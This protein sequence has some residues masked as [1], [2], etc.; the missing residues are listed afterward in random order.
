MHWLRFWRRRHWDEERARELTSYIEHETNENRARGMSLW[1][2]QQAAHRKLGNQTLIREEIYTMNSLGWIETLWQDVRYGLRVLAKS[3]GATLVAMISLAL[4]IGATTAIFSAFYGVLISPYPYARPGEIW[5]PAIVTA[6]N[7]NLPFSFH[8][9]RDYL[10]LKKLPAFA[11]AMAT[12]PENRLL[13][14]GRPPE[15][16]Q[17]ISVTANAFQFLAVPPILGRTILPSDAAQGGQPAPVIVLSFKAWNRLFNS[18]PDALGKKLILNDEPFTV[19]GV[20]PPRFGWWTDQGGWLVLPETPMDTR[21]AAPIFRL[22]PGVPAAAA[23]QQLHALYVRL[24]QA[25]PNDFP[26]NGFSTRLRN[27]LDIT[28]ASGEMQSSLQLLFGAVGFLLLIACA[29]V[30]NLQ[31]ARATGRAHEIS[32]RMSLGAP[33]RRL[34][35][36]LLTESMVLSFAGGV[37][38]VL[39]AIAITKAVVAL[40]P[41]DYVPNEARITVNA[42]ALL[43][44]AGVSVLTGIL[45]GLAPA[46][47]S[48]RPDLVDALKDAGR[49]FGS[50]SGGRARHALVVAEIALSVVLLMGASLTVRGFQQLESADPGFQADRVLMVGLQLPPKRYATYD[51]RVRFA[52]RVLD[53]VAAIPGVQSTAI[54]NGGLPYAGGR[55]TYSISGQS[56]DESR[57]LAINLVSSGYARTMGIPLHAGRD[58]TRD[59][60][61]RAEPVALLNETAA[62]LWATGTSAIGSQIHLDFL[63][64]PNN[65]VP[66]SST[67]VF[68]IV[69][70]IGDTRNNGLRHPPLP[71]IYLPYTVLAPGGRTLALRTQTN[72]MQYLNAVRARIQ[73]IDKDQPLGHPITMEEVLGSETVQPRFNMALFSFFGILGLVLAAIGIYSMLS[74]TVSRRT[75]EI[76]IRMALGAVHGD[77][78]GLMLRMG[79]RLVLIGLSVGLGGSLAL[80]RFLRSE[81]FEVPGTDPMVIGGVMALLALTAFLACLGPA[82]RAAQLDP[83]SALRHE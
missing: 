54:G 7:P 50:G 83:M 74:Y 23:E 21:F 69:G 30:A 48:S 62:K 3:P 6:R 68:T 31:L 35:R 40:M 44:C 27:Y 13:T 15:T 18:S 45:F 26:K 59:E 12:L 14:G 75:H 80:D 63:D 70:I 4:G 53:S 82:S 64:R 29:N 19:I 42:Y 20:M 39:L 10:E 49:S 17:A 78:L 81:V 1:E 72:P 25:H 2:A 33:R 37:V 22:K 5:A 36:Q 24:A 9:I 47:R 58:L 32:V 61:V 73:G 16:F 51:Q 77:V 8:R 55:S 79:G 52:E 28:S 71:A 57:Q 76:G 67:P 65:P 41:P 66:P 38:G 34:L 56:K 43:F 11:D 46:I 60:V